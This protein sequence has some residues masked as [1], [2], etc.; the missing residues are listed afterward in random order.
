M[1][2]EDPQTQD[3]QATLNLAVEHH[4]AGRLGEAEGLYLQILNLAPNQPDALQLLGVIAYQSGRN[5]DAIELLSK[6]ISI[7][8]NSA[9]AL[10]NLGAAYRAVERLQDAVD[11]YQ[12]ALAINPN[13]ADAHAN[14]G[15]AYSQL[16][17]QNEAIACFKSA[18]AL[19][20]DFTAAEMN[21]G[22]ELKRMKRFDEALLCYRNVVKNCPGFAEAQYN[23]GNML[24]EMGDLTKA[25]SHF[26]SATQIKPDYAEAYGNMGTVQMNLKDRENAELNLRKAVSL[27]PELPKPYYALGNIFRKQN[28][29]DEAI[30]SF[31]RALVLDPDFHSAR[32]A[33]NSMTGI[34]SKTAPREYVEGVF[35]VYADKFDAQLVDGL[36]YRIPEV[37]RDAVS[38]LEGGRQTYANAID[39]GC[40]TGLVGVAFKDLVS[41]LTG[42]DLSENMVKKAKEKNVYDV[43]Y[44]DEITDGMDALDSQYDL[45]ISADV[46]I[47]VGAL[48]RL[49]ESVKKHANEKSLFV[50]S[51]E[52]IEG[53]GYVLQ[54]TCRYAHSKEY[55]LS[56]AQRAGFELKFFEPCNLRK[57]GANWISGGVYI[58][59]T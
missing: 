55:I 5:D 30:S 15:N 20:P 49:F 32:H 57:E 24:M 26:Q 21:L 41:H 58:L 46:L 45:F 12:K 51:T 47:Y 1:I 44:V 4:N 39:L 53:S 33:L 22:N 7:N 3:I 11:C 34:T 9:N 27:N 40:G 14:L 37:L 29:P 28:K 25:I 59:Q 52:H 35:N 23:L 50:F 19:K 2:D 17:L 42:I 36:G 8:P 10:C 13:Y 54:S 48:D 31:E 16:G 38:T 56:M 18:L 6:S 43:L